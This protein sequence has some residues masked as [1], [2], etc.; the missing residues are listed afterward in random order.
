MAA[1]SDSSL[2]PGSYNGVG[3]LIEHS[4]VRGGRKTI[5]HEFPNQDN[6]YV[7]DMGLMNETIKI[8]A[9]IATDEYFSGRDSLK[10][11]FE[12]KGYGT[13]IHPFYGV[14]N[15]ACVDYNIDES[16][17]SLGYVKLRATFMVAQ[18]LN[19]PGGGQSTAGSVF[20][21]VIAM[22]TSINAYYISTYNP[23][24]VYG[25]SI[26]HIADAMVGLT[27]NFKSTSTNYVGRVEFVSQASS[28]F[29]KAL[30]AFSLSSRYYVANPD[31]FVVDAT[32]LYQA[33]DKLT[34]VGRTGFD[35]AKALFDF[36]A[37]LPKVVPV[38][39]KQIATQENIQLLQ[40]YAKVFAFGL[41]AQN[42]AV[43]NYSSVEDYNNVRSLLDDAYITIKNNLAIQ[44]LASPLL[45]EV[46]NVRAAAANYLAP[47]LANLPF[48]SVV[49]GRSLPIT[50]LTYLYYGKIDKVDLIQ[51]T[52]FPAQIDPS[53]LVGNVKIF[54]GE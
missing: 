52:N 16:T 43:T 34:T 46:E 14:R 54:S 26:D 31:N 39:P 40:D 19:F 20:S 21:A 17:H 15:C 8:D 49:S 13:L 3:F 24:T 30:A 36:I 9:S 12:R 41:M 44:P 25:R 33:I 18:E 2:Y 42:A 28:D 4:N 5:V 53:M 32:A 1:L 38:T 23:T 45:V 29:I 7:E 50:V 47:V 11:A 51:T 10:A 35:V 48:L 6:R 37:P 27:N 22:T